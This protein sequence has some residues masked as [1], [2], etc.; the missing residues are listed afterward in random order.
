[1]PPIP[2]HCKI[3]DDDDNDDDNEDAGQ[4]E[5]AAAAADNNNI[6]HKIE[7]TTTKSE[8]T[9]HRR[10]RNHRRSCPLN[11]SCPQ[12]SQ[13][14]QQQPMDGSTIL[15]IRSR[16][17]RVNPPEIKIKIVIEIEED[18]WQLK[19]HSQLLM[20]AATGPA[21]DNITNTAMEHNNC[22][23]CEGTVLFPD[24][25]H[26]LIDNS[27]IVDAV[28]K[29]PQGYPY[30]IISQPKESRC[31]ISIPPFVRSFIFEHLKQWEFILAC[32][33]TMY[34]L[35]ISVMTRQSVHRL[36]D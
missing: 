32:L 20:N 19:I 14:Q 30:H 27:V 25:H 33:L 18:L 23:C 21:D 35:Y 17:K 9:K 10:R 12:P 6:K 1:M 26:R 13:Q 36:L 34:V 3:D 24:R 8:Q 29:D 28:K 11:C 31:V 2:P 22:P 15:M 4:Q 7:K 5:S 16:R